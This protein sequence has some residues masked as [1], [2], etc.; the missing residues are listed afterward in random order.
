VFQGSELACA[1]GAR[2]F[3]QAPHQ[4]QGSPPCATQG[5][6][7]LMS[8]RQQGYCRIQVHRDADGERGIAQVI[9][10]REWF[11]YARIH[12][13]FLLIRSILAAETQYVLR[14]SLFL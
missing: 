8:F 11:V 5:F 7:R 13:R 1:G 3:L 14:K 12:R 6:S 10:K 9:V 2:A 4:F